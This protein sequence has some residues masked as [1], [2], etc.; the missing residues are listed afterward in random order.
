MWQKENQVIILILTSWFWGL[1]CHL[2]TGST[3]VETFNLIVIVTIEL[4]FDCS[5]GIHEM[6]LCHEQLIGKFSEQWFKTVI[7]VRLFCYYWNINIYG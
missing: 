6:A 1:I 4:L 5:N 2:P 3:E 7:V